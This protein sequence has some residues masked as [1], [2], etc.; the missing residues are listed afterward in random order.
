MADALQAALVGR[1]VL[2]I[3]CGTGYWTPVIAEVARHVVATD[4]SKEM[5]AVAREKELPAGKVEFRLADAYNLDEVPGTFDAAVAMFWLSH[6]SKDRMPEFMGQLHGRLKA[7]SPVVLADNVFVSG[8]GGEL[9]DPAGTS[10]TFKRRI[11][12]DGSRHEVLKNFYDADQLRALLNPWAT[13]LQLHV[14][15]CFWWAIYHSRGVAARG[16]RNPP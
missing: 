15:T 12:A 10:D 14:G 11:L 7:G 4:V 9:I 1:R 13:E 5:L 2:E 6:V 3:A 16:M 8:I